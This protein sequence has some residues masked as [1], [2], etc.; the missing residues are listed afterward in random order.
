M[1]TTVE[2]SRNMKIK[3]MTSPKDPSNLLISKS[4]DMDICNSPNKEFQ[5]GSFR[6][7]SVN[8][9]F[10]WNRLCLFRCIFNINLAMYIPWQYH[11]LLFSSQLPFIAIVSNISFPNVLFQLLSETADNFMSFLTDL[12]KTIWNELHDILLSPRL[13]FIFFT[14]RWL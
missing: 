12:T 7:N 1:Q 11:S 3:I 4:K 13:I 9:F 8:Q 10:L 6:K 14:N 2:N 5:N